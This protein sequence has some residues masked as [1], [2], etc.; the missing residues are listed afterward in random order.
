MMFYES[1]LRKFQSNL[2]LL[3]RFHVIPC[4]TENERDS[5]INVCSGIFVENKQSAHL[6]FS[7]DLSGNFTVVPFI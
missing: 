1:I 6:L 7:C 2:C 3:C 4:D 5:S